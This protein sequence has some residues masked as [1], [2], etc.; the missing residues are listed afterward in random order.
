MS[1]VVHP[2]TLIRRH[3]EAVESG[4]YK[5]IG[6]EAADKW[7]TQLHEVDPYDRIAQL[8]ATKVRL[9]DKLAMI[10]DIVGR[11]VGAPDNISDDDALAIL[12]A[13]SSVE[14]RKYQA[15]SLPG[16]TR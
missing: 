6:K 14:F 4:H 9:A 7:R 13:W 2:I 5:R 8:V 12:A 11:A 10:R 3:N 16:D 15:P 1:Q